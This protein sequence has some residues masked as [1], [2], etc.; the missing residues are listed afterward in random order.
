M[1]W[2]GRLAARDDAYR[3]QP[4]LALTGRPE[5]IE[6]IVSPVVACS[7]TLGDDGPT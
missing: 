4:R 1:E 6:H 7:A 2:A 5:V 3:V